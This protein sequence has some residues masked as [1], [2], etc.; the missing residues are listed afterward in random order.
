MTPHLR[1]Q[2]LLLDKVLRFSTGALPLWISSRTDP[3]SLPAAHDPV[4][5]RVEDPEGPRGHYESD[6]VI[7]H[8]L[9]WMGAKAHWVDLVQ[10][11]ILDPR[12][13]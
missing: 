3:G 10:L 11:L 2:I 8:E 9:P 12:L 4:T 7:E 1:R 5:I 6:V 13:D